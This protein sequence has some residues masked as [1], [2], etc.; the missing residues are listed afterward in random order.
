MVILLQ[1]PHC[2]S[3]D[4]VGE[5]AGGGGRRDRQ[6]AQGKGH[7]R[8]GWQGWRGHM[9]GTSCFQEAW[10]KPGVYLPGP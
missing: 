8:A 10:L 1:D 2:H 9:T 3:L 6:G 4:A 5:T 7:I